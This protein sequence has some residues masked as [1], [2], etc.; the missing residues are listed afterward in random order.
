MS[1]VIPAKNEAASIGRALDALVRQ[2]ALDGQ[3]LDPRTF[4]LLVLCNDCADGTAAIARWFAGKRDVPKIHVLEA[5]LEPAEAHVGTARRALLDLASERYLG[6]GRPNGIL[7]STDADSRADLRWIAWTLAEMRDAD[8]VAGD[9]EVE[10]DDRDR[11]LAP[12]RLLYDRERTYR[13]LLGELEAAEDPR[14]F[15]PAPRHDAFVGASFAVKAAVYRVAGGL[16]ARPRLEDQ[17]FAQSLQRID[18]RVRHSYRV[19][20]ATSAR[21]TARV[22]GGFATFIDDLAARGDRRES[23][24]VLAARRSIREARARAAFRRMSSG[25]GDAADSARV[26]AFFKLDVGALRGILA[27]ATSFGA[28]FQHALALGSPPSYNDEPVESAIAK[29]RSALAVRKP[30]APTL[31]RTASGAG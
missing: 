10:P 23:F 15:D 9:V 19:R 29:L 26:R 8:A 5:A 14:A 2:R 17:A 27:Q 28:A 21:R 7:A 24:S 4:E 25:L 12:M 22:E 20:V 31:A 16:P 30:V 13:R 18:A 6:A 11:M 3:A 1:V